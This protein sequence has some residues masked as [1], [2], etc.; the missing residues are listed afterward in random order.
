MRQKVVLGLFGAF[1]FFLVLA[2]L[3]GNYLIR[4]NQAYMLERAARSL[5]R[6]VTAAHVDVAFWPVSARLSSVVVAADLSSAAAELLQA[7]AVKVEI[8]FWPLF[9]GRFVPSNI[10][11]ESPVLTILRDDSESA[12]ETSPR[13]SKRRQRRT[14]IAENPAS[15]VTPSTAP[16]LLPLPLQISNGTIRYHDERSEKQVLA[17]HIQLRMTAVSSDGP[18]DIDL[19]ASVTAATP[20]LK[21]KGRVGPGIGAGDYRDIPIDLALQVAS[22]DMGKLHHALPSLKKSLPRVLQFDGVYSTKDLT[23]K[24]SLNN[25]SIKGAIKG[26]DASVRFD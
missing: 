3:G 18:M 21:L 16:M 7:K 13:R 5:G 15:A 2:L 20:N 4:N 14:A 1:S 17:S 25:P 10:V 24:G 6:T 26:S 8:K 19:D 22:L 23:I 11:L 9:L 12:G